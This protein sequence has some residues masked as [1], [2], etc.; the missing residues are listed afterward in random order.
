M[1]CH[2]ALLTTLSALSIQKS[3]SFSKRH[4]L[5][6]KIEKAKKQVIFMQNDGIPIKTTN[7]SSGRAFMSDWSVNSFIVVV[8]ENI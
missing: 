4:F 3:F 1:F 2:I 7:H 5:L 8:Y 6:L